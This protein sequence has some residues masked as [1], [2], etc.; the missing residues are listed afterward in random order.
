MQNAQG[1]HTT[2]R[3]DN[4]L[5][6]VLRDRL[7]L[8]EENR[9]GLGLVRSCLNVTDAIS[10]LF[11]RQPFV[12]LRETEDLLDEI[13]E[14]NGKVLVDH[15]LGRNGGTT[16]AAHGLHNVPATGRV[17]IAST[18]PTGM[19]DFVAHAGALLGRRP[20]LK[21]VANRETERF[22]GEDSIVPVDINK[23]NR[24]VSTNATLAA[25]EAHLMGEGALLVFGSG[26]VPNL[27]NG[28]L[29]EPEWRS[30]TT[31]MSLHC[32]TQ[33]VPA[34]LDAR[35]TR[36]YYG[37]RRLAQFV[38]GGD[39]NFGAMVGS[40][41]YAAELMEKLGGSYDVFYGAPHPPGTRPASLKASAEALV[42]GLYGT[43][44]PLAGQDQ[45]P[46]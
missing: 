9:F 7:H 14:L 44:Q 34:A 38:S 22:L 24:A 17:I 8:S 11:F 20:D 1:S 45:P 21:V 19:F 30:G 29:V 3:P 42:P 18:H 36:Y 41:R 10:R 6:A 33:V 25:M 39:E 5:D 12:A 15:I 27:L 46:K 2:D 35:N 37:L 26:R 40:L 16:I 4:P 31:R 13:A 23:R 28:R 43:S 32:Q